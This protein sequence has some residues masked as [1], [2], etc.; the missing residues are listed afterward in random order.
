[1]SK[2]RNGWKFPLQVR[3]LGEADKGGA[4]I[5]PGEIREVSEAQAIEASKTGVLQYIDGPDGYDGKLGVIRNGREVPETE[6][7]AGRV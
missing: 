1:M 3:A 4:Y 6:V 2:I 5:E 7:A